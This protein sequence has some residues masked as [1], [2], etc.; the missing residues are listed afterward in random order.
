MPDDNFPTLAADLRAR[1]EELLLRSQTM[2]D[3]EAAL[4]IREIAA[5]YERLAQQIEQGHRGNARRAGR[6]E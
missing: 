6:R 4:K 1:A 3:A 5:S 2:H